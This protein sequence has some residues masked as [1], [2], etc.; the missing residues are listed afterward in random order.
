MRKNP[1][2]SITR[3]DFFK[4]PNTVVR[5]ESVMVPGQVFY[6]IPNTTIH[7]LLK[8]K[9]Q[10]LGQSS[11][12]QIATRNTSG[13]KHDSKQKSPCKSLPQAE[14][15]TQ[16][17]QVDDMLDDSLTFQARDYYLNRNR[18]AWRIATN[19][20]QHESSDKQDKNLKS[21]MKKIGG[22]ASGHV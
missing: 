20:G 7:R 8:A 17:A 18:S 21:C 9:S 22:W 16:K 12:Q 14:E 2:H 19:Y 3:P 6:I 13:Y 11:S 15:T 10:Q 5:P 4:Y 1:R